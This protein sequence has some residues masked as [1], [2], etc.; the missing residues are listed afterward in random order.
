MQ[1]TRTYTVTRQPDSRTD[2]TYATIHKEP[3]LPGTSTFTAG[4]TRIRLIR[5]KART[6]VP[7]RL[8][9]KSGQKLHVSSNCISKSVLRISYFRTF[10]ATDRICSLYDTVKFTVL[11]YLNNSL[12]R[13]L[14]CLQRIKTFRQNKY[15]S[16]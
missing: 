2:G 13:Y 16:E 15:D 14:S 9:L 8:T 4:I 6:F 1:T 11:I 5:F 7:N 12:Y 3:C 10:V